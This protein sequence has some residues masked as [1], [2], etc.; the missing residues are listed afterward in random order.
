MITP[1]EAYTR[2]DYATNPEVRAVRHVSAGGKGIG[3]API[4]WE[5][6][7]DAG[8][9]LPQEVRDG[10]AAVYRLAIKDASPTPDVGNKGTVVGSG[11]GLNRFGRTSLEADDAQFIADHLPG[12]EVW[13]GGQRYVKATE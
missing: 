7:L 4:G 12:F 11:G 6:I 1:D 10:I 3:I 8:V 5:A 13:H 2:D 9:E